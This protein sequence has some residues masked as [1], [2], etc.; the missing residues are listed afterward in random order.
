MKLNKYSD[1]NRVDFIEKYIKIHSSEV[2]ETNF[3]LNPGQRGLINKLSHTDRIIVTKDRQVGFTTIAAALSV[4]FALFDANIKNIF[5]GCHN[6]HSLDFTVRLVQ[7]MLESCEA[8]FFRDGKYKISTDN[9]NISFG[10]INM[11]KYKGLCID[12]LILDELCVDSKDVWDDLK[13][14]LSNNAKIIA[15]SNNFLGFFNFS[16]VSMWAHKS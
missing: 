8:S 1:L 7:K 16:F 4:D 14:S 2:G 13:C 5:F 6:I 15:T 10:K 12:L 3:K 11:N 9:C